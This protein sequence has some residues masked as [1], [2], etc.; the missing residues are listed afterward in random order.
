M[1]NSKQCAP[2]ADSH[3][4]TT[5]WPGPEAF[6]MATPADATK[7]PRKKN[8]PNPISTTQDTTISTETKTAI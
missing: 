5:M 2:N 4:N 1:R 8:L 3:S 6:P 7:P